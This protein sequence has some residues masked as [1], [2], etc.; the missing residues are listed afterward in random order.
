MTA[1]LVALPAQAATD[2]TNITLTGGSLDFGTPFSAGDFPSTQL[3]GSVQT[4]TA[5]VGNWSVN[6]A[7]GSLL[8]WNVTIAAGQF[9]SAGADTLPVGSLSLTAPTVSAGSGQAGGLAPIVQSLT[10]IDAGSA[11]PLVVAAPLTGQGLW[12]FTQGAG[13]LSLVVPPTV[14]AGTYTS[15]ITTTLSSL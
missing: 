13:Q 14:K 3:N 5:D 7:R 2:P 8:G 12:N 15:T 11:V 4:V 9:T 1:G 6:D 10:P